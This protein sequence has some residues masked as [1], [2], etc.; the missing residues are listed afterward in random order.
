M[1][2]L[3]AFFFF[4]FYIRY[5]SIFGLSLSVH[6]LLGPPNLQAQSEPREQLEEG[7]AR[8]IAD[9]MVF[10]C[11]NPKYYLFAGLMHRS[12]AFS[13]GWFCLADE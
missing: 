2:Q 7:A 13:S 6:P 10:Q 9:F 12:S 11:L 3:L 1:C 5:V 4:S 8:A